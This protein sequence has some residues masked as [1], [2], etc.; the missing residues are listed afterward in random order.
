[1]ATPGKGTNVRVDG[2]VNVWWDERQPTE[3]HLTIN[4]PDITHPRTGKE[5]LHLAVSSNPKSA[6]FHPKAFNTL[7]SLLG[8][9]NKGYP[10]HT[11]DEDIPRRIGSRPT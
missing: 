4:D 2:P 6:N 7:R 8:R 3:I 1:M 11:A 5:G 9:F 10:A